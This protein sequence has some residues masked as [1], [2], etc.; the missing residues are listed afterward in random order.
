M[1]EEVSQNQITAS[2]NSTKQMQ[3]VGGHTSDTIPIYKKKSTSFCSSTPKKLRNLCYGC[4]KYLFEMFMED[5]TWSGPG[6]SQSFQPKTGCSR[7][8]DRWTLNH[9]FAVP[10]I[11]QYFLYYFMTVLINKKKKVGGE[12]RWKIWVNIW[13]RGQVK[14]LDEDLLEWMVERFGE[15]LSERLGKRFG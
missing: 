1:K 13:L 8:R 15:R 11:M 2:S 14:S 6:Q 12:V 3:M 4:K 10:I 7:S 9:L 5:G